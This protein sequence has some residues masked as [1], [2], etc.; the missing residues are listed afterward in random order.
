[1]KPA[2]IFKALKPSVATR[3]KAARLRLCVSVEMAQGCVQ[4]A[5]EHLERAQRV[6]ESA[7]HDLIFAIGELESFDKRHKISDDE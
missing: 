5:E 6:L 3:V 1:M 4:Q 7:K 2:D